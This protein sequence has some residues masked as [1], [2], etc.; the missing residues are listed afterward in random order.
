MTPLLASPHLTGWVALCIIGALAAALALTL[1]VVARL[2]WVALSRILSGER[3]LVG[4]MN[5]HRRA[6]KWLASENGAPWRGLPECWA[7]APDS[8]TFAFVMAERGWTP[9]TVDRLLT[10]SGRWHGQGD[11]GWV[12]ERPA[13]EEEWRRA[14]RLDEWIMLMDG[15]ESLVQATLAAGFDYRS[16]ARLIAEGTFD[17]TAVRALAALRAAVPVG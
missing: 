11:S 16:T 12:E 3:R 2:W 15:D 10:A 5:L 6:V 9:H 7:P 17:A 4:E 1:A 14:A 8:A 13:T